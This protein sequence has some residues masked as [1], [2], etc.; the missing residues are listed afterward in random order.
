MGLRR[1]TRIQILKV[2][3]SN[4]I[5]PIDENKWT[6]LLEKKNIDRDFAIKIIEN[7]DKNKEIILE[8]INSISSIDAKKL[9][10]VEKSILIIAFTEILFFND[11]PLKVTINEAIELAKIY[12][13]N[14]SYK[15][16]NGVLDKL[17]NSTVTS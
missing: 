10:L 6:D 13:S 4:E 11:I 1:K 14:E 15:F 9:S 12:G 3:Y 7:C 16:I 17:K 2:I 8:K 5:N